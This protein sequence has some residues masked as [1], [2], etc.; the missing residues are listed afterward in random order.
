MAEWSSVRDATAS[1][2]GASPATIRANNSRIAESPARPDAL[3]GRHL[4]MVP[5]ASLL[6]AVDGDVVAAGGHVSINDL[7][8]DYAYICELVKDLDNFL[9][10]PVKQISWSRPW[11][12]K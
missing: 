10:E 9:I 2:D 3:G 11:S 1:R 12:N 8:A 7:D 6:R 5:A 4:W